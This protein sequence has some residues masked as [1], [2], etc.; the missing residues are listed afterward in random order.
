MANSARPAKMLGISKGLFRLLVIY[1]LWNAA[2]VVGGSFIYL[3]FKNAGAGTAELAGSFLFW[4]AA[5][6]LAIY[7]FNRR[8]AL[9]MKALLMLGVAAQAVAYLSM[10]VF[11]PSTA[12]LCAFSFLVGLSCF[13]FW[14]PFNILYFE[15]ARGNEASLSSLYFSVNPLFGILLPVTV[16]VIAQ[17]QGFAPVFILALALYALLLPVAFVLMGA[18]RFS[19]SLQPSVS[20]LAGFRSLILIEGIYGGGI[21]SAVAVISASYFAK[22]AELGIFIS[23]TTLVSLAASFIISR[24]SDRSGDRKHYITVSGSALGIATTVAG[25]ASTAIGWASAISIRNFVSALFYPF[26]TAIITERKGNLEGTMVAREWLLN[27]GRLAGIMVVVSAAT[28]LSDIALSLPMLGLVILFYP[29]IISAK[30]GIMAD[31]RA[32]RQ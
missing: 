22:P 30:R 14:A 16:G 9:G 24:L 28:V 31:G 1:L 10:A 32:A 8:K 13:L 3:Y 5:P 19:Y 18:R 21:A 20:A 25:L 27:C 17:S 6:I 26:T 7:A 15:M 11:P 23:G 4:A 12:L 29:L 2:S